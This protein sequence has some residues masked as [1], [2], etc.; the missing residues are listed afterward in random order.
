M[1]AV[2]EQNSRFCEANAMDCYLSVLSL[3]KGYEQRMAYDKIQN[4]NSDT[5]E[6]CTKVKVGIDAVLVLVACR[7]RRRSIA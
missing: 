5:I 7:T 4:L 1:E 6:L 2:K 3:S